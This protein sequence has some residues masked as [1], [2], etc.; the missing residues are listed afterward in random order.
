MKT[1]ILAGGKGTRL[2]PLSREL[3]PKQFIKIFNSSS[4]FQKT[5]ERALVFSKPEEIFVVANREYKFRIIDDMKDL[6]IEIPKENVYLEPRA[7][8]TLPAIFWVLKTNSGKFAILPSDH[9]VEVNESYRNAFR[10]A[11]KLSENFLVTFGIKPTRPHT[12]Y[13]YIKPGKGLGNGFIVDEFKE[14]PDLMKAEEFFK[15]GYLWNSG[16]FFFDSKIFIE[17]V[18]KLVPEIFD[19]FETHESIE[20][21]YDKIPEMSVDYG[22]LEKS[23]KV[24]VV[25]MDARWSDLGSFDSLYEISAKDEF[26]NAAIGEKPVSINSKNNLVVGQKLIATIGVEKLIIVDTEDALL[27]SRM[28]ESE[29]VREIY[30]TLSARN[31]R[32]VV[33]HRTAFRPWGS[34]TVLEEGERYKIKRITIRPGKRLSLQRHYHRSEHWV[35]VKGTARVYYDGRETILRPGEST[36]IP[37]GVLHRLENPGK[38]DLEVIETQIGEYL[39]EDDIERIEDDY[40]RE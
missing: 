17:E 35:V 6:N 24:A 9:F 29:K 31:D 36:F 34:Y 28:G 16:M 21:V 5:L 18:K 3:M 22:I 15:S 1:L 39:E 33:V 23:N 12:G 2:W 8:S 37:A 4:L 7:R 26:G 40:G 30:K 19:A 38:V 10:A 20:E 27:V 32:R 13:G 25:P 11:E 14:K